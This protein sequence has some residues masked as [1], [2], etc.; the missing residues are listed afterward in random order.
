MLMEREY[1]LARQEF[2]ADDF[3]RHEG[4]LQR[5]QMELARWEVRQFGLQPAW[6]SV[7]GIV[8]EF[9][10]Y[11]V[12]VEARERGLFHKDDAPRD[13]P[14]VRTPSPTRPSSPSRWRRSTASRRRGSSPPRT[15]RRSSTP[16]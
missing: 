16:A 1:E 3:E 9:M 6:Q 4:V 11:D 15:C 14:S 10:E 7:L 13:T 5:T 12:A 2:N 8:E